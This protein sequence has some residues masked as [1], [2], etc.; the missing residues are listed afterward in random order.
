M[1]NAPHDLRDYILDELEPAQRAELERWLAGSAE[2][3]A[4]LER[5]PKTCGAL[6]SLPDEEP[7]RRIAFV[8]DKI[9]EPSP[10]ARF[11]RWFWAEGPRM[12]LG[13]AAVLA[14][15]FAG[16]WAT[17]PTV[18]ADESGWSLAFGPRVETAAPAPAATPAAAPATIDEAVLE[19]K[20]QEAVAQ[21]RE[22]MREALRQV[23][24]ERAKAIEARFSTDL[25]G[26]R[27][28]FDSSLHIINSKYEQLY[29]DIVSSDLAVAR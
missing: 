1:H 7:P 18:T 3:R 23:I 15:V 20:V 4:E 26:T 17:E 29:K 9:F 6:R 5:L 10:W 8:S 2:G 24:D 11:A 13:T 27:Q 21:E 14:V 12:A 22:R 16:V 28:D 19:A 25:E